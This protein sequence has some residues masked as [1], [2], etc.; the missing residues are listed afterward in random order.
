LAS[1]ARA[2][3]AAARSPS[4]LVRG[5]AGPRHRLQAA[6]DRRARRWPPG[7]G[8]LA[9]APAPGG[10]GWTKMGPAAA[11]TGLAGWTGLS[12]IRR[13]STMLPDPP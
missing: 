5:M 7:G 1:A 3:E 10:A 8:A 4:A 9:G 12:T 2:A 13:R 6:H 11:N